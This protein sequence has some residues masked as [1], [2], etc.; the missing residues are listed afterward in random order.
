MVTRK[1]IEPKHKTLSVKEQCKLLS[2]SKSWYY[3]IPSKI[4]SFEDYRERKLVLDQY[5]ETPFYGYIKTAQATGLSPKKVR[6]I[7]KELGLKTLYPKPKLSLANKG[8]KKYPYLLRDLDIEYTNQVW[9][10]DITYL[11]LPK[12]H[13]YLTAIKDLYSRKI[14]SWKL[15]NSLDVSFCIDAV[16]E[17]ISKYGKPD[18]FNSDQGSQYTSDDFTSLLKNKGIKIS[19]DGKG[20]AL[21]NIYIERFWRS[22]KY[23]NIYLNSYSTVAEMKDGID[24]YI[25]FFNTERIH[26]GLEYKTPDEIYFK[27]NNFYEKEAA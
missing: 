18:I 4:I 11:K 14:L 8:H 20:R 15:S 26:Q 19:M 7:R 17:A 23:E 6:R 21:D 13:V 12:G 5:L 10:T 22:L 1:M 3:Y 16:N 27:D 2:V 24:K 9:A 25:N